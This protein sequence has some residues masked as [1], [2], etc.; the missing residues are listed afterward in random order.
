[1]KMILVE[2]FRKEKMRKRMEEADQFLYFCL[3]LKDEAFS[4]KRE[5]EESALNSE[6]RDHRTSQ[7]NTV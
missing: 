4:V 2:I 3:L 7:Q 6:G 5:M 1:M